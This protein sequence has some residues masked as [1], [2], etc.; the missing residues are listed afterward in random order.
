MFQHQAILTTKE[1]R[2]AGFLIQIIPRHHKQD[3]FS[4]VGLLLLLLAFPMPL[5]H[6]KTLTS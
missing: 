3:S 1:G 6:L 5:I 4:D 2:T